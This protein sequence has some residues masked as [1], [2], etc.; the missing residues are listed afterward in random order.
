MKRNNAPDP[1][2]V[3]ATLDYIA[4]VRV[5]VYK[6]PRLGT[7]R[8]RKRLPEVSTHAQRERESRTAE[9]TLFEELSR[10]YRLGIDGGEDG[11]VGGGEDGDED[12]EQ[13]TTWRRPSLLKEGKHSLINHLTGSFWLTC[14]PLVLEDLQVRYPPPELSTDE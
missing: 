2:P 10:Y 9:R 14:T 7:R 13:W 4:M 12:G 8:E 1:D 5:A 11:S 3:A 6:H